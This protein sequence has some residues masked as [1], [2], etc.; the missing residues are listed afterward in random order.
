MN[1]DE[2]LQADLLASLM[3]LA[4]FVEAKDPYTGGHLWRVSRYCSIIGS[5]ARLTQSQVASAAIGGFLHDLGKIGV[6]DAIL[7]KRGPL[8]SSEFERM[9][10]HPA[11]GLRMLSGHPLRE[12]VEEAVA[13]HHERPDGRGYPRGLSGS[14]ISITALLVGACDS[15][16]AMT[17]DRPYRKA[18]NTS[19]ALGILDEGRGTQFDSRIVDAFLN[20]PIHVLDSVRAHSDEGIPL[21]SCPSCGLTVVQASDA[22][23]GSTTACR[24][25]DSVFEF[26]AV[27]AG[28][29][30][31]VSLG[32]AARPGEF[33]VNPDS[34]MIRR[35]I[36]QNVA[37][38]RQN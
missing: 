36:A 29:L 3:S 1:S 23:A 18:M 11:I 2:R 10:E 12:L 16:D 27:G 24:N 17:S 32:R 6:P 30:C 13:R 37:L 26:E 20:T 15:F 33:P 14:E 9:K 35:V 7:T 22:T 21:H 31:A 25:C 34:F 19:H 38:M 4:W 5:E 8:D 28:Q